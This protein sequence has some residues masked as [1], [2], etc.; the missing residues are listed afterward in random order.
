LKGHL[1]GVYRGCG[2]CGSPN[3]LWRKK[4]IPHAKESWRRDLLS[5]KGGLILEGCSAG[6]D[7]KG[8]PGRGKLFLLRK[9]ES[10]PTD[11]G[12]LGAQ[13]GKA[14]KRGSKKRKKKVIA[15][16]ESS[17]SKLDYYGDRKKSRVKKQDGR[18]EGGLFN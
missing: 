4:K 14:M 17:S 6:L 12:K 16:W 13:W 11:L 3:G 2:F 9:R 18:E 10:L 5:Q 1:L 15:F 8:A 7:R